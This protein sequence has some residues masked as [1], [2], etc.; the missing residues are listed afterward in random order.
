MEIFKFLHKNF[1]KDIY[2]SENIY[3][4]LSLGIVLNRS[5]A[6]ILALPVI[7]NYYGF[8]FF[9]FFYHVPANIVIPGLN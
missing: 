5:R 7:G 9:F 6:I 8:G 2:F 3:Q 1:K 4:S